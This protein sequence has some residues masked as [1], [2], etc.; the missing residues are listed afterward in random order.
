[1]FVLM[2]AKFVSNSKPPLAQQ[3]PALYLSS[4]LWKTLE[5]KKSLG[6]VRGEL[7]NL[8]FM[9]IL[10]KPLLLRYSLVRESDLNKQ[11][12]FG[13]FSSSVF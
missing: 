1:M 12:F 11:Q 13:V 5:N 9:G 6:I 2:Q 8:W 4:F 10:T 7:E 3:K